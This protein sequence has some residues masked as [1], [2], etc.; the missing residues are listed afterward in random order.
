MNAYRLSQRSTKIQA[1]HAP[2]NVELLAIVER[3]KKEREKEIL[4]AQLGI[5]E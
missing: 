5:M 2:G 3:T 4:G 1:L